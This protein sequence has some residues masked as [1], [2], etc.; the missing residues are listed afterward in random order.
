MSKKK[1]IKKTHKTSVKTSILNI[2]NTS[3]SCMDLHT[4][5]FSLQLN[6]IKQFH[7]GIPSIREVG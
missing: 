2:N 7:K 1:H 5:V 3:I 6:N 4:A